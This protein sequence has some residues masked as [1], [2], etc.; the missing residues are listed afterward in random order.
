M[1]LVDKSE[2][3]MGVLHALAHN[4]EVSIGA[5]LTAMSAPFAP[6]K[7]FNKATASEVVGIA[8]VGALSHDF[9]ELP[10]GS[11][12]RDRSTRAHRAGLH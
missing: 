4:R 1:E 9:L 12:A 7:E 6:S 5:N 8:Q 11:S 10:P 2:S 3:G